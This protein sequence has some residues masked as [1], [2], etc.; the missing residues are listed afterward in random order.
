MKKKDYSLEP[1]R[2]GLAVGSTL[3]LLYIICAAVILAIGREGVIFFANA[4]FHGLDFSTLV[5]TSFSLPGFLIGL[6]SYIVLGWIMG[7]MIAYIYN[8]AKR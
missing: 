1:K 8:L 5:K 3:G 7:A 4:L 2:F 6:V